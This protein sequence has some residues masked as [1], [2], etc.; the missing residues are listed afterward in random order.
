MTADALTVAP[1]ST[2]LANT[3]GGRR[4]SGSSTVTLPFIASRIDWG[5]EGDAP[6]AWAGIVFPPAVGALAMSVSTIVVALNAKL[7]KKIDLR[8]DGS[9]P[10]A[11]QLTPAAHAE[12]HH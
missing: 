6:F 1:R 9:V 4:S 12:P 11:E 8:S 2:H 5:L 10:P 3:R 7:L